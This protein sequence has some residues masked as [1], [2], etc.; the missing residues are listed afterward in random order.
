MFSILA[1][2]YS[3]WTSFADQR[4][5]QSIQESKRSLCTAP[6]LAFPIEDAEFILD[7]DAS[8]ESI[9]AVLSQRGKEGE[10]KVIAYYCKVLS[11]TERQYCVTRRELLAVVKQGLIFIVICMEKISRLE[12]TTQ[13]SNAFCVFVNWTVKWRDGWKSL[14]NMISEFNFVLE[15]GIRMRT[16]Y[17]DALV[18]SI[19]VHTVIG[20]KHVK[21]FFEK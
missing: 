8:G 11:R 17:R 4:V 21:T 6:V 18:L 16:H 20:L 2:C 3:L 9:G 10:E 14:R 19:A 12:L 15:R 1:R 5:R 7:T 13:L